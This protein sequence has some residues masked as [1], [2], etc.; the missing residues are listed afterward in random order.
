MFL[1]INICHI[2]PHAAL[3]NAKNP[4]YLLL[5]R[6]SCS[7]KSHLI[8]IGFLRKINFWLHHLFGLGGGDKEIL[9]MVNDIQLINGI[10]KERN[11]EK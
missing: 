8:L 1:Q 2:Y 5:T 10:L 3:V 4:N 9:K 7:L 6:C 11:L